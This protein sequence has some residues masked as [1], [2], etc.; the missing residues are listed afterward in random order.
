M[1]PVQSHTNCFKHNQIQPD[2]CKSYRNQSNQIKST[3]IIMDGM[4]ILK[5]YEWHQWN[6]W[7]HVTQLLTPII[8]V[9]ADIDLN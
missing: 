1:S 4:Q 5:G 8:I 3:G 7:I 6:E 9:N 2:T